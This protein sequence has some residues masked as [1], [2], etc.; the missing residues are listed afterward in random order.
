M[1]EGRRLKFAFEIFIPVVIPFLHIL[2]QQQQKTQKCISHIS[3]V[4]NK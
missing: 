2:K 1:L 4:E 3:Y